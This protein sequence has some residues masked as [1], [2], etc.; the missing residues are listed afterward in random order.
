M[1]FNLA[2]YQRLLLGDFRTNGGKIEIAEF[3]TPDDFG[4]L[5]EKTYASPIFCPD[6]RTAQKIMKKIEETKEEHDS[7]G[8]IIACVAHLPAGL[9]DP[10]YGKLEAL[11]ASAMLSLPAS[12]GF[13]IGAGFAA[14]RAFGR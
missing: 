11:L 7:L 1:M 3:H 14:A 5:R 10:V 2:S 12:K 4:K 6:E 13:E 9:G 8:G